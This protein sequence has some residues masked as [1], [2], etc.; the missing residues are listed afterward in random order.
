MMLCGWEGNWRPGEKWQQPT[1]GLT[2]FVTCEL[3]AQNRHRG[4]HNPTLVSSLTCLY[5]LTNYASVLTVMNLWTLETCFKSKWLMSMIC[6]HRS[7][8][9][10]RCCLFGGRQ[11]PICF[12]YRTTDFWLLYHRFLIWYVKCPCNFVKRHYNQYFCSSSSH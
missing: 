2:A 9:P 6:Q 3:I 12:S 10:R 8:P 7:G 11:R 5:L 4:L 1:S